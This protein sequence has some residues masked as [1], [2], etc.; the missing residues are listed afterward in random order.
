MSLTC[1]ELL[2]APPKAEAVQVFRGLATGFLRK[3]N[4]VLLI[5]I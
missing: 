2:C 4:T 1:K 3:Q 5:S